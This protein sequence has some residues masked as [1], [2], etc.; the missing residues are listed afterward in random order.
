LW[1]FKKII[2]KAI[3]IPDNKRS[4]IDISKKDIRDIKK[5]AF[6]NE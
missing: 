1:L 4:N 6:E 2:L 5:R 3:D